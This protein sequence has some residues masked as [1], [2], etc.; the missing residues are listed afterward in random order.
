MEPHSYKHKGHARSL[1]P[2]DRDTIFY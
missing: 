2:F 1:T